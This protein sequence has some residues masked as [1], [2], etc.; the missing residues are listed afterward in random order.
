VL[1]PEGEQRRFNDVLLELADRIGM[2][3]DLNAAM[4]R[5]LNLEAPY[6]LE[7]DRAYKYEEICDIDLKC[8][9]GEEHGLAWFKEHGLIKW[10]KQAKEVYWR[11]FL[12]VRVP[13]YWEFL[14]QTGEDVAAIAEPRGLKI[15]REFYQP[16]P[17][18]IP[19]PSHCCNAEGYDFYAFYYRD[20][21]HTNS[22]TL[23]NPWLDEAAKLDP[24]SYTVAINTDTGR[25]EGFSEGQPVWVETETG[26]RVKG[27]IR[28]TETIHPEG[29]GIAACA[30]HW[31][32]GMPIAKDKGVAFN[33]LLELD[34]GHVS[35][36]NLNLDLCVRVKVTPR[37]AQA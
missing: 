14:L 31:G 11:P 6:R 30:G 19:C 16:M 29:L 12:D 13:I 25:S 21:L 8:Q 24:F 32:D 27:R 37:E 5:S 9:F 7:G 18:F 34:W 3:A 35:P 17:D 33:A 28:L 22:Y 4:N 1:P 26:R 10:P 2:R 20:I 23:E 15:A 36:I